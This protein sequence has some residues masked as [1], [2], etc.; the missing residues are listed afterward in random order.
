MK[1][2]PSLHLQAALFLDF[3]GTLVDIAETPDAVHVPLALIDTIAALHGLLGG[4]LAIVSGRQIDAL[5]RFLGPLALAAAGE[6]GAQRRN[7]RG[8]LEE[9]P[10]PDLAAVVQ[11]ANAL[12]MEDPGVIVERKHAA[13][14]VHYRLAQYWESACRS[15]MLAAIAYRPQLEVLFGKCVVEVKRAGVNKGTAIKAFME[16][17]PFQG[18]TPIFFGDDT[19]DESG[20]TAVQRMHGIAVKVGSG[21]SG[22]LH[23]LA[24]PAALSRWL[25]EG[26]D[27]LTV[28]V[29]I[30]S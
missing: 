27:R 11:T 5:D 23:R 21:P 15:A 7:A 14:A 10:A 28:D 26:R 8:E 18:R 29:A 30:G 13:V 2:L 16:E 17:V 6:H 9:S 12:S 3:D 19:T 24:D 1:S 22:A 20:F 4:A 25:A